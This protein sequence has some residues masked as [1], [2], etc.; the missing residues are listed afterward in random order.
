VCSAKVN[1][2]EKGWAQVSVK[3]ELRKVDAK[4]LD[5]T[6]EKLKKGERVVALGEIPENN[7][8]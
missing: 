1:K 2:E 8:R 7:E 3:N 4:R 5:K 6:R